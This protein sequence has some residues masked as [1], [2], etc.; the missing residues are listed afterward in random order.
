MARKR[1]LF[2][3]C[4]YP[5]HLLR[6]CW[7]QVGWLKVRRFAGCRFAGCRFAAYRFAG[8][9]LQICRLKRILLTFNLQLFTNLQLFCLLFVSSFFLAQGLAWFSGVATQ[10]VFAQMPARVAVVQN[11]S[12]PQA[13][14]EQGKA[15]YEAG[16]YSE[17]TAVLREAATAFQTQG[18]QLK[19]AMTL[20]NLALA[21]QQLG[22]W[23]EAEQALTESLKLLQ[24]G[25]TSST[26]P[27]GKTTERLQI[28]AQTL[29]IQGRWQLSVGQSQEAIKTWQQAAAT[30]AQ[31]GNQQGRIQSQI[32]QAQALQNLGFYTRACKTV[33]NTLGIE[34]QDCKISDEQLQTL[35]AQPDSL[36]KTVGL[37]TLGDVLQLVGDLQQSESVLKLSLEMAQRLQSPANIS[38]ARFSLANTARAQGTTSSD[39]QS[40]QTS[41]DPIALYQRVVEEAT[42]P[43]LRIQAQ[44]NQLSLLIDQNRVSEARSL[45]GQIQSQLDNLP[46][47]RTAVYARINLAQSLLKLSSSEVDTAAKLLAKAVEQAK[48]IGDQRATTYALGNLGNLYE[49]TGQ[50]GEAK[51]LTEEALVTAQTINASDIAYRWQWQLGRLLKAQGNQKEAIAAYDSAV[52]TLKDLRGDLVSINPDVQFSFRESVEP[53][54]RELVELLLQSDANPENLAQARDVIESLQLAELANFFR[55][56]CLT[57]T[58]IKIDQIDQKAAVI[59][60]IVLKDR[61][62]VV[63]SLP[64]SPLRHYATRLPREQV[65]DAF[66]E[67]RQAI[68]P[69]S[70][71][72]DQRGQVEGTEPNANSG[73]ETQSTDTDPNRGGLGAVSREECRGGL[74][75]MPTSCQTSSSAQS[76]LPLAQKVYEWLIRPVEQDIANSQAK[77]LVFVLDG[78]MLNLPMAVLNDGKEFLIEKYAIAYTPGLNLLDSK[79]LARGQL[80]ALKAGITKSREITSSSSST[81]LVFSALPFVEEE[82]KK[83][84]LKVGGELLLD[85]QFTTTAIQKE[86]NSVPF[87]VVHLATHG[88]FSSNEKDTFI[89]TWD[90]RLNV[91]QLNTVLR[92][93][94]ETGRNPIELLVL[95][96]CQ[97]AAGDRRAALGLAGVAVRAGARSTLATLW[98]VNDAATAELMTRFYQELTDTSI[99]KA[100]AL[101]RAQVALLKESRYQQKPE[102]WAPYVLVGNWL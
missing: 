61:L 75:P 29:D 72:P 63:L 3:Y 58:A 11:S 8:Y 98:F 83:I 65:E 1:L 27:Q 46:P 74:V 99:S 31:I 23:S 57:G 6:G 88:Q 40:R 102:L 79:P 41:E 93:R 53:V 90:D 13:L 66:N 36:T 97:T 92:T 96:A 42:S 14:V 24:S 51:D 43:T 52:K 60:P 54:Y 19:A 37:R 62:E 94:E 15:L 101:R 44:L 25:E 56:D 78:P 69:F 80:S 68:A 26:T 32:N 35:K 38:A 5:L 82:L 84:Q 39:R 48:R 64:N 49:K 67:L 100:E 17:A 45:S 33:L 50:L 59:Y 30:Y 85:D 7:L 91:N 47:T 70:V 2:F 86:I 89:L 10:P 76:Y 55:E 22:S 34:N 95:S 4:R 16:K 71:N 20:S 77:T 12:N 28:L 81:P 9:R 73:Q 18:D 21:Y 87:P